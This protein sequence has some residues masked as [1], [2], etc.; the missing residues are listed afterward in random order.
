MCLTSERPWDVQN[1]CHSAAGTQ[2]PVR[3]ELWSPSM[4][5]T[6]GASRPAALAYDQASSCCTLG[7]SLCA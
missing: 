4:A 3:L 5:A 2:R 7:L 1:R 6:N